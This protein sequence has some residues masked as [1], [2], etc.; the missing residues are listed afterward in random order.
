M[1]VVVF[2]FKP[3]WLPGGFA[4][5]DVFFVISGFLMT[6]IIFNGLEKNNFNLFEFYSARANR[7]IPVIVAA[8]AVLAVF[9]WFYLLPSDYQYLA[10]QIQKSLFFNSNLFF[11]HEGNYFDVHSQSKWLL[12]TWSLSVEWQFYIFF[13]IFLLL[14]KRFISLS[15]LKVWVLGLFLLSF[16]YSVYLSHRDSQ[17]AYFVLSSRAWEMLLGGLAF[18]YPVAIQRLKYRV[19]TQILGLVLII[20]SYFLI[21]EKTV[22]PGYMALIPVFGA[23]LIIISQFENNRLLNNPIFN[24]LGAWSYSIYVWH[25]P[26]L[27][28]GLYFAIEDWWMYGIPLAILLGFLSYHYI[29]K[30]KL[31]KFNSWHDIYKV[32]PL[33]GLLCMALLAL[34]IRHSN[35]LD[36]ESYGR[37]AA[38]SA[39]TK[40]ID[41]Y[42]KQHANLKETYWLKCNSYNALTDHK[43]EEVDSECISK[44]G[45]GGVFLWGD[46][47]AEALSFGLRNQLKQ[48]NIPFYQKTSA[49]CRPSIHGQTSLTGLIAQA[50]LSSNKVALANIQKLKPT[51]V[52]IAQAYE[53]DLT[54]WVE[55]NQTLTQAGVKNVVLVG[56]VSQWYPSLPQIMIKPEHWKSTAEFVSDQGLD[57][58]IMQL[59]KKLR[60]NLMHNPDHQIHY[61]SLIDELCQKDPVTA[62]Y[63]CRVRAPNTEKLL[64]VDYG[65]LSDVG[66]TFVVDT[67]ILKRL[68]ALYAN[69]SE[70]VGD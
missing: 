10:K 66:S 11:A 57:M 69:K 50:C 23:Y 51:I 62:L 4:G 19:V 33:Y 18:L 61:I 20:A 22:W 34:L 42:K 53:H 44:K 40:F 48:A 8:C 28:M 46:S 52:V 64:Q 59:E 21:S 17:L 29:E 67:I 56:P 16:S 47:H 32:K 14:L 2:H 38:V 24:K 31:P 70:L 37:S 13:P 15:R 27:V 7:I 25:W 6:S 60:Q 39:Q 45:E 9:G 65:H 55:I 68:M 54:D 41:Y 49:G 12:H 58:S 36:F 5:V 35:G 26:V 43:T 63:Q 3:D 30:I 1:A